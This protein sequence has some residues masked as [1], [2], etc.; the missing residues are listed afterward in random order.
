[1]SVIRGLADADEYDTAIELCEAARSSAQKAKQTALVKGLAAKADEL[2]EQQKAAQVYRDAL[3]VMDDNPA[4]PTANLTAGRYLCFVKGDWERGVP[5]L[6]L[7][8]D[9]ELKTVAVMDLRGA[10][11][12]ERAGRNRRRLVG[13]GRNQAGRGAGQL[14]APRRI[15]VSAGRTERLGWTW[16]P[17]DHPAT[18]RNRGGDETPW[19]VGRSRSRGRARGL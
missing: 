7:G 4:E 10:R 15:L 11:S 12:A 16:P 19:P 2:K 17:Q 18:G 13:L 5:Y 6:A 8:S 1:M 14:S 3:A 9:A